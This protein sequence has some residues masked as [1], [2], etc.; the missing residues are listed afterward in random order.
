MVRRMPARCKSHRLTTKIQSAFTA[1]YGRTSALGRIAQSSSSK[2]PLSLSM[3][4]YIRA[5]SHTCARSA[6]RC[7]TIS[8]S[9]AIFLTCLQQFSDSSSLA[10]HRRIHSGKRPYKCPF[11]DCQKTFTRR[12]TL[13]RHQSNHTTTMQE[14]SAAHAAA[15]ATHAS[16][17]TVDA[18]DRLDRASESGSPPD[19][20]Q[21]QAQYQNGQ[22]PSQGYYAPALPALGQ[23]PG[24]SAA[25]S[26][27]PS[28]VSSYRAPAHGSTFEQPQP[29]VHDHS[30]NPH[31]SVGPPSHGY[32]P[33]GD[34]RYAPPSYQPAYYQQQHPHLRHPGSHDTTYDNPSQMGVTWT[35]SMS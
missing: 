5:R 24:S 18:S 19:L 10:R 9:A 3:S 31:S 35:Q 23:A 27:T 12:T 7:V 30:A 15:L 8:P 28:A 26:R 29:Q 17:A 4:G 21:H 22:G 25:S 14:A 13:T 33:Y 32:P 20:Q 11:P 16:H 1:V 2:D 6:P 34:H